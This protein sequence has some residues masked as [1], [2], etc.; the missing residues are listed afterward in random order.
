[1]PSHD[2]RDSPRTDEPSPD[3]RP[4]VLAPAG[5]RI[6]ADTL[7]AAA[8]VTHHHA[9]RLETHRRASMAAPDQAR[10]DGRGERA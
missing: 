6:G 3:P 10:D 7:A 1:M 8:Q 9:Q 4:P 5:M 2:G